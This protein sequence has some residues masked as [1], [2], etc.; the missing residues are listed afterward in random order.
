[1]RHPFEREGA[2]GLDEASKLKHLLVSNK[3]IWNQHYLW[4]IPYGKDLPSGLAHFMHSTKK[5][6]IPMANTGLEMQHRIVYGCP[7]SNTPSG[8][9]KVIYKHAELLNEMG[10]PAFVWHPGDFDFKCSWFEH[11]TPTLNDDELSPLTDF[12]VLPEIWASSHVEIFK[13]RGFKVGIY[14]QNAYMTHV[15]L[16]PARPDAILKAYLDADIILSISQDTSA[17]IHDILGVSKEKIILQRYSIDHEIFKPAEKSKSITYMPRKMGQHSARVISALSS[18]LPTSWKIHPIDNMSENQVAHTLSKSII[19]LAFSEFEGL[20]VPPVEAALAGNMVIGYHGQGGKEYWIKP[21]FI[22]IDQGDIR[23]FIS[24]TLEKIRI[25]EQGA[26]PIDLLNE[27]IVKI[28]K[29]FSSEHETKLL[30]EFN[31]RAKEKILEK[32]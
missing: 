21:N 32:S 12:I 15:N 14:V 29:H 17:Y 7:N 20:P 16:A 30:R 6:V 23:G 1:M 13:L 31:N 28:A 3:S 5:I 11:D 18:L 2:A 8:G 22:N 10:T 9:V 4:S 19:F 25:I 26:I 27:G 24:A